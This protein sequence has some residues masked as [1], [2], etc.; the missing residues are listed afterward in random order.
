MSHLND[1]TCFRAPMGSEAMCVFRQKGNGGAQGI[2]VGTWAAVTAGPGHSCC[3]GVRTDLPA[4]PSHPQSLSSSQAESRSPS[5]QLY[6]TFPSLTRKPL[7]V[8][9]CTESDE[10][11]ILVIRNRKCLDK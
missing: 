6:T 2:R 11:C 9:L 4:L 7:S 3:S 8:H 5:N 1:G 10:S